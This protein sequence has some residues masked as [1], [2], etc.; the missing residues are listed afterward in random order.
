[1]DFTS[2]ERKQNDLAEIVL[3][4]E[5]EESDAC[6]HMCAFTTGGKQ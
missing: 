1:M 2:N 6:P 3:S 5:T 4:R